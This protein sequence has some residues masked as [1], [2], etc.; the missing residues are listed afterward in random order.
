MNASLWDFEVDIELGDI[1]I[2]LCH[3]VCQDA[4]INVDVC[5]TTILE[6]EHTGASSL[7]EGMA[8]EQQFI[9]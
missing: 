3:H 5:S 7:C 9:Y 4:L 2:W 6:I 8:C 1:Q